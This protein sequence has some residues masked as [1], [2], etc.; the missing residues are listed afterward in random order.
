MQKVIDNYCNLIL[1]GFIWG[2]GGIYQEYSKNTSTVKTID[3]GYT[4]E[5]CF[6]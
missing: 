2:G 6:S 5:A 3:K 4:C 1:L